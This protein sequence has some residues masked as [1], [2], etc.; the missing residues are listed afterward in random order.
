MFQELVTL[1]AGVDGLR[2]YFG[3]LDG[4]AVTTASALTYRGSVGIF[5][6]ATPPEHRGNGYGT[7]ITARA[8]RDGLAAR[9][10]SAWLQSS[11]DGFG[12]YQRMGFD[13]VVTWQCWD[14]TAASPSD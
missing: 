8:V 2:T 4:V 9:A 6:V 12:V 1:T 7:T 5:N 3:E 14:A 13:T 10:R 11:P